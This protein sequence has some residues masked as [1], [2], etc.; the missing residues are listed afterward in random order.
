MKIRKVKNKI[1]DV[2]L[3]YHVNQKGSIP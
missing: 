1:T 2:L 3:S